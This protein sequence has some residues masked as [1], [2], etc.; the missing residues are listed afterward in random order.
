M[1]SDL[2]GA[3]IEYSFAFEKPILY[4]VTPE[5]IVQEKQMDLTS[6]EEKIRPQIGEVVPLSQLTL[7]PSKINQLLVS[8]NR[9]KEKIQKMSQENQEKIKPACFLLLSFL[10]D[11]QETIKRQSR[12][13]QEKIKSGCFLLL[14]FLRDNQETIKK[15]LEGLRRT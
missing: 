12:D 2:S 3:A 6:L 7:I 14:S 8:E 11:N 9:F 13:N 15:D 10:R 4:V 5:K 1:I